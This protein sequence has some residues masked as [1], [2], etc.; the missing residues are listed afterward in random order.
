MCW[1]PPGNLVHDVGVTAPGEPQAPDDGLFSH[2]VHLLTPI[3][4]KETFYHWI[5]TRNFDVGDVEVSN[6]IRS[7]ITHAFV[8]ED[9]PML[10]ALQERMGTPDLRS[11]HP[12]LLPQDAPGMRAR[13]ITDELRRQEAVAAGA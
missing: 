9:E 12:V 4:L 1:Y 13:R 7:R 6:S 2:G 10:E 3:S 8:E 5:F 11:L